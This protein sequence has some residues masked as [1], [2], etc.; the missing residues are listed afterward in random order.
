MRIY[1]VVFTE[2]SQLDAYLVELNERKERDHRKVG[3]DLNLFTFNLL[4]G[5]GLPIW[6]PKGAIIK[7]QV[8]KFINELEF[9]L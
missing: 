3:K 9:G 2:Q 5:Q 4:A 6:L 7:K 1:G 8:E